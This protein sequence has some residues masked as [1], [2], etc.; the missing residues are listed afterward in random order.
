MKKNLLIVAHHMTVGGVQKSLISALKAIDYDKY[1]V[2]LYLRKNR[3]TLLHLVDKRVNV[4]INENEPRYYRRP[5]AVFYQLLITVFRFFG[6]RD[7]TVKYNRKLSD[8]ICNYAMA[9]EK[10]KY[11]SNKEYDIAISYVHGYVA[12][13]TGKCINA[14]EKIFFH[15]G[16]TDELRA[17]H[18]KV[19]TDFDKIVTQSANLKKL[20]GEWY[21]EIKDR[22]TVVENYID[23]ETVIAQSKEYKVNISENKTVLCSCGRFAPVKGFDLAVE[24][25]KI[26]RDKGVNFVWYFV[27]DGPERTN[28]ETLIKEYKLENEIVLTGMQT[29]PYPYMAVSNIYIQPSYE[30]AAGLTMFEAHRLNKPVISTKTVGGLKLIEEGKNGLLS[31]IKSESMAKA[32]KSLID[33]KEKYKLIVNYLESIDYSNEF[34]RYKNQWK[35]LLEG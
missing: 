19:I 25:A 2:T 32:V 14:K 5:A 22:I 10:K 20:M 8:K 6:M 18:E 26:L 7:K 24:A 21:P 27:G 23:S 15:Q 1:N 16:S 35:N 13:F 3:T 11:F 31:G 29:N 28:L 30:E 34:S 9:H 17:V 4:I 12:L 33:D